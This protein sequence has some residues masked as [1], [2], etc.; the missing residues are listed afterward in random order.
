[1]QTSAARRSRARRGARPRARRARRAERPRGRAHAERLTRRQPPRPAARAPA[2]AAREALPAF[3]AQLGVALGSALT[4]AILWRQLKAKA[5]DAL[6]QY[7]ALVAASLE[8][9]EADAL[10][11][12]AQRARIVALLDSLG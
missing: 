6:G 5:L 4:V 10:D 8:E 1:M 11:V 12:P 2:S 9:A 7:G 3:H